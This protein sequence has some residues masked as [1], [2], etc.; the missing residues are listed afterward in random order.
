MAN[1]KNS[2]NN[3]K[4][5]INKFIMPARSGGAVFY[6]QHTKTQIIPFLQNEVKHKKRKERKPLILVIDFR[7]YFQNNS[8]KRWHI[9][10]HFCKIVCALLFE[11]ISITPG[12]LFFNSA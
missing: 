1:P 5:T 11:K 3:A 7:K 12:K 8:Q 10:R 9:S 4:A 6:P 2:G